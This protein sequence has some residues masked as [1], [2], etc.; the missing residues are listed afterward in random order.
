MPNSI[1]R[2]LLAK[3]CR[4]LEVV[5]AGSRLEKAGEIDQTGFIL[6]HV[7]TLQN[8]KRSAS[9]T[10]HPLENH[11]SLT[12]HKAKSPKL[13]AFRLCWKSVWKASKSSSAS[14]LVTPKHLSAWL[15]HL[16]SIFLPPLAHSANSAGTVRPSENQR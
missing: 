15:E 14:A 12:N 2:R 1:Q 3:P 16:N 8:Q 13:A 6:N 10:T 9:N 11:N 7:P 4:R 5:L